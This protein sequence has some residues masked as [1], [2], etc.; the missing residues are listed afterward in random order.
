MGRQ[1]QTG[2]GT[3]V[4]LPRGCRRS[5]G[6][7]DAPSPRRSPRCAHSSPRRHPQGEPQRRAGVRPAGRGPGPGAASPGCRG[8]KFTVAFLL[9]SAWKRQL[10][11]MADGPKTLSFFV[12][13]PFLSSPLSRS[14]P[15]QLA[16]ELKVYLR[17][18]PVT[19]LLSFTS[20]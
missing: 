7:A 16:Q 11:Y 13:L 6:A 14:C 9:L 17:W 12:P 15:L 19:G 10:G 8:N 2:T 20:Q 4:V 1:K 18:V 5:L 3:A